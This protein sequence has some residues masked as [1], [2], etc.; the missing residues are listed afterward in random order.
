MSSCSARES[1]WPP[2]ERVGF[3][4]AAFVG[5]AFA[6]DRAAAKIMAQDCASFG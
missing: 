1:P 5:R 6:D 3:G 2:T 4:V